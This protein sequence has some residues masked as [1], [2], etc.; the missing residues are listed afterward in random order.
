MI[1]YIFNNYFP[2]YS[3]F[4]KR[5]QKEIEILSKD[6]D[7]VIVCRGKA[8][9]KEKNYFETKYRKIKIAHFKANST[10]IERTDKK[11]ISGF[12]ELKRNFDLLLGLSITL[13][14][15][16]FKNR[17]NVKIYAIVSPLT[18]P[19]IAFIIAKIFNMTPE[20]IEFHDLEPEI[21]VHIKGLKKNSIVMKIEYFLEKIMCLWYKKVIVTNQ[22][23]ARIIAKRTKIKLD[24]FCVIPN[25]IQTEEHK[26]IKADLKY[27]YGFSKEDFIIGYIS[28]FSYNYT[29][30]GM[31]KLF[32]LIS[33][34]KIKNIKF[35][36]VGD[37]EGLLLLKKSVI[38]L[39]L[40]NIVIF[41]GRVK[42][43]PDFINIFDIGL[44]PWI[45]NEFSES[46][47]PTKLFEY[48]YAKKPI[49][50]PNFGEFKKNLVHNTNSLLYNTPNEL[51]NYI[52]QLQK[53]KNLRYE[54]SE[55]AHQEYIKYY[56]P[57]IYSKLLQKLINL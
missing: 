21:A 7:I 2:V 42:N 26:A 6:N 55:K 38:E 56:N 46:I 22:S 34:R 12:Y 54:L 37:G 9:L 20:I 31:I 3:G 27:K 32:Y 1:L 30:N 52:I 25:S 50:A 19:L 44:I 23:Q 33:K 43:S 29:I 41:T 45:K 53:N 35:I 48:M 17:R 10:V 47:L 8:G 14:K 28:N 40:K 24:K 18:V 15:L 36:L 49:L 13:F 51:Y 11:Y 39:G 4:G 16:F 5:C 57:E